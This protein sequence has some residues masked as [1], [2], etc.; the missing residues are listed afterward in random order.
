MILIEEDY[1]NNIVSYIFRNQNKKFFIGAYYKNKKAK[2]QNRK[3]YFRYVTSIAIEHDGTI[4]IYGT[5]GIKRYIYY[6]I[7]Q[8]ITKYN[9]E[10]KK[11]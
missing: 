10:A 7:Q 9:K 4:V 3:S 5:I 2:E 8:A 1:N 6:T 11:H